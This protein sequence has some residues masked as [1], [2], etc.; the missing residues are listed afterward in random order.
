MKDHTK[1]LGATKIVKQRLTVV[2]IM[3]EPTHYLQKATAYAAS[4][5][6]Q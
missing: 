5:W 3:K 6:P 4:S 2:A 1:S